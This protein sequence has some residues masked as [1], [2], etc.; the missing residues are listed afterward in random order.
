LFKNGKDFLEKLKLLWKKYEVFWKNGSVLLGKWNFWKNSTF[1]EIMKSFFEKLKK[2]NYGEN[3]IFV[4]KNETNL[5]KKMENVKVL[6][7]NIY[8]FANNEHVFFCKNCELTSFFFFR[9]NVPCT[10]TRLET[11]NRFYILNVLEKKVSF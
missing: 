4:G 8:I 10:V 1:L 3:K 5:K 11:R 7:K 2:T 6:E 9:F